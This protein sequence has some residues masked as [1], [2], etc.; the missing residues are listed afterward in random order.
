MQKKYVRIKKNKKKKLFTENLVLLLMKKRCCAPCPPA[1]PSTWLCCNS[2]PSATVPPAPY[3]SCLLFRHLSLRWFGQ[4][5][6]LHKHLTPASCILPPEYLSKILLKC[7]C[8]WSPPPASFSFLPA[9]A[10]I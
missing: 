1:S 7:T 8:F 9:W 2:P 5:Q 6:Q 3:K 10:T 4:T